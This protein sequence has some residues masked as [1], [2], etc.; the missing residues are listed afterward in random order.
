MITDNSTVYIV[1]DDVEFRKSLELLVEMLGYRVIGFSSAESFLEFKNIHR[2]ACLIL[3]VFLP[4]IDGLQ[5]QSKLSQQ[6][7]SLPII[8]I[9]GHG[10]IP[11]GINAMKN[12]AVDFL[13]KP[14]KQEDLYKAICQSLVRDKA[15]VDKNEKKQKINA[16]ISLL[17]PRECEV[18]KKMITGKL[19]KQ[20]AAALGISEKTVRIHRSSLM[21]KLKITSVA[22]LVRMLEEIDIIHSA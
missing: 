5:L 2:P 1:D 18:M 9:T 14:F 3:D 11:M 13:L 17:T 15:F 6:P 20:I 7:D 12:G 16:S 19:N 4:N 22:D 21:R 8:F 10:E